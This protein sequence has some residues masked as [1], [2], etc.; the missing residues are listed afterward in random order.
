LHVRGEVGLMRNLLVIFILEAELVGN[1]PVV[2]TRTPAATRST[3]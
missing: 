1:S 2:E 3:S